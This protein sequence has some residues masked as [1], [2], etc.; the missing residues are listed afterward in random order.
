MSEEK[1]P[2]EGKL[3]SIGN[4][5]FVVPSLSVNDARKYWPEILVLNK[6]ITAEELPAKWETILNII[7]AAIHRNYPAVT[8]EELGDLISTRNSAELLTEV[9]IQSG[10]ISVKPTDPS[11]PAVD[12]EPVVH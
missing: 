1:L 3:V 10:F 11:T 6:G 5:E 8:L 2:F 9:A 12:Q 4:R 7:Y